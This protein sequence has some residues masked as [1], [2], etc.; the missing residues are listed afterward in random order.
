MLYTLIRQ[1]ERKMGLTAAEAADELLTRD[2][3]EYE[4]RAAD[5]LGRWDLYISRQSANSHGGTRGMVRAAPRGTWM[6]AADGADAAFDKIAV[7]VIEAGAWDRD[8]F[9]VVTD[10]QAARLLPPEEEE[11]AMKYT[12]FGLTHQTTKR[13][14]ADG[15]GVQ[16]VPNKDFRFDV[17]IEIDLN[18]LAQRYKGAAFMN[19][20]RTTK[21]A[22]GAIVIRAVNIKEE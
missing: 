5:Y 18:A 22:G 3:F 16:W 19:R 6:V 20:N 4:V 11:P 10:E 2:G 21:Q 14:A 15:S 9:F 7:A 12:I 13:I 8:E 17:V 1:R